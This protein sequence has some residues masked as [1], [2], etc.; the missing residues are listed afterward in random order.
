MLPELSKHQFDKVDTEK[1]YFASPRLKGNSD[2]RQVALKDRLNSTERR[3]KKY[4]TNSE[5]TVA[6]LPTMKVDES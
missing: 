1:H 4:K 2:I 3:T 6:S 5:V